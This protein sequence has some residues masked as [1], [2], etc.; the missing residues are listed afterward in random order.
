VQAAV[1]QSGGYM[2]RGLHLCRADHA[3][4]AAAA[5]SVSGAVIQGPNGQDHSG[6]LRVHCGGVLICDVLTA[7]RC[8]ELP[9]RR[10][11]FQC[12]TA[13]NCAAA[14]LPPA[15]VLLRVPPC[16][17]TATLPITCARISC[18]PRPFKAAWLRI[19]SSMRGLGCSVIRC[20][21]WFPACCVSTRRSVSPLPTRCDTLT[22]RIARR[23]TLMTG[24]CRY[25]TTA[26]AKVYPIFCFCCKKCS[27]S[28]G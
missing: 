14:A 21:T 28:S 22:L 3:L 16:A 11:W 5:R 8:W 10:I 27:W 17:P 12:A 15:C 9:Q 25:R 13:G 6:A 2:E 4:F 18:L 26:R 24:R 7:C 19:C 20:W 1:Q 23:R